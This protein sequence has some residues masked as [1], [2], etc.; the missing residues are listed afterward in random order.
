MDWSRFD[1]DRFRKIMALAMRADGAEALSALHR[2]RSH[3]EDAGG[4]FDDLLGGSVTV[5]AQGAPGVPAMRAD[6]TQPARPD[7]ALRQAMDTTQIGRA[8]V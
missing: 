3:L 1:R 7:D 8:H 6:A 5:H 2:A 4:S